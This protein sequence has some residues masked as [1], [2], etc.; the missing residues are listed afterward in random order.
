M[1]IHVS[2]DESFKIVSTNDCE[3]EDIQ[4]SIRELNLSDDKIKN[5]E[6]ESNS[7]VPSSCNNEKNEIEDEI[8]DLHRAWKYNKDHP[9]ELIIRDTSQGVGTRSKNSLVS[10]CALLSKIKPKNIEEALKNKFWIK[11]MQKELTQFERNKV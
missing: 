7:F 3:E 5:V 11:A 4:R 6:E 2:F 1:T 9:K 10:N 8:N